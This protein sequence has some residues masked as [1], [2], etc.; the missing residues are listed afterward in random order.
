MSNSGVAGYANSGFN[1]V[2]VDKIAFPAD[3]RTTL[4]TGM[5]LIRG[6]HRGMANVGVAGYL[7]GGLDSTTNIWYA[8]VDKF[9]F[10]SDTRTTVASGLQTTLALPGGCANSGTA[11]YY[12]Y[13]QTAPGNNTGAFNKFAFPSDSLTANFTYFTVPSQ[14]VG[15]AANKGVAA[16]TVQNDKIAFSTDTRSAMTV[17]PA[18]G[19]CAASINGLA[20]YLATGFGGGTGIRKFLFATETGTTLAATFAANVGYQSDA[21]AD[22]GVF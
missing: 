17:S 13:G 18:G 7:A 20:G 22:S 8:T 21:F 16:Y 3:T 14:S 12:F 15:S 5:S 10:P 1:S 4:A 19:S 6:G 9:A 2:N 11:G